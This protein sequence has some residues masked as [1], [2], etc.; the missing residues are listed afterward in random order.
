MFK[1]IQNIFISSSVILQ[2]FQGRKPKYRG[3]N[4][5]GLGW[6]HGLDKQGI[7]I[8]TDHRTLFVWILNFEFLLFLD[9]GDVTLDCPKGKV[10]GRRR[11]LRHT[12]LGKNRSYKYFVVKNH[13][14]HFWNTT[15]LF[16]CFGF[17]FNKT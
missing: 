1:R 2:G 15:N 3:G 8:G 10:I 4:V 5:K 17:Y 11:I 13:Q 7:W 12:V 14:L 9:H 16:C 6:V